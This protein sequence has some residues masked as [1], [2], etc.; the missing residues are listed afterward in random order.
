M[1][2]NAKQL[3]QK[4]FPQFESLKQGRLAKAFDLYRDYKQAF[5]DVFNYMKEK[6]LRAGVYSTVLG[7]ASYSN[8]YN[9]DFGSYKENLLTA[10]NTHS[11]ISDLIRNK[12]SIA[13]VKRLMK[14]YSE[15]RL[16]RYNLG[17]C[18]VV[19]QQKHSTYND[20]FEKHCSSMQSR[21]VYLAEWKERIVDVGFLG[22]WYWMDK[23]MLDFDVNEDEFT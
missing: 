16:T 5:V 7:L 20:V 12:Q 14:L 6:P 9:P 17:V 18:S 21:W 2:R 1:L 4:L 11:L 13:E 3:N 22:H 8:V 23:I 19:M 15:D 10:S